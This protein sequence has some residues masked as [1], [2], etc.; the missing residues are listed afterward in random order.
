MYVVGALS[1]T[2]ICL[3]NGITGPIEAARVARPAAPVVNAPAAN[4]IV[5]ELVLPDQRIYKVVGPGLDTVTELIPVPV[6]LL[7]PQFE[8]TG[9]GLAGQLDMFVH[10]ATWIESWNPAAEFSIVDPPEST[11]IVKAG[12]GE[13]A[14]KVGTG[15]V[16]V[17]PAAAWAGAAAP[18]S[19][20]PKASS[21]APR[22]FRENF[23]MLKGYTI[24]YFR[25][26]IFREIPISW[27]EKLFR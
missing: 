13:L 3:V 1:T 10:C 22:V 23:F 8:S 27:V 4:A 7:M 19:A 5:T 16:I 26:S 18:V 25:T 20:R 9:S 24:G 21:E 2:L 6:T 14:K 11:V 15:V 12:V 17:T